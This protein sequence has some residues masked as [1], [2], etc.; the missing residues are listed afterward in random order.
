MAESD[1]NSASSSSED[2]QQNEESGIDEREVRIRPALPYQDEPVAQVAAHTDEDE[3]YSDDEDED[4]I[5]PATLE[6]RFEN[7]VS[8]DAWCS[9]GLCRTETLVGTREYRC[10]KELGPAR[11]VMVFDG[12]IERIRCIT[13]HEDYA[14]LTNKTVLSLVGPLLRCRNGRSYRR[15]ANQSENEYLRAVAY[16]WFVRWICGPM[17]WENSRPLS[18]CVYH[19][20]RSELPS[21]RSRGYSPAEERP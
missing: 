19:R 18:A 13:E 4:G 14:A 1:S 6:A 20:I 7:R 3:I 8:V 10:C 5:S 12:T 16:R 17:G 9:F 11:R 15:S 21:G 2:Q